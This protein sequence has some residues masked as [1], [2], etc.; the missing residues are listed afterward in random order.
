VLDSLAL[1]KELGK[2]SSSRGGEEA[3]MHISKTTTT[4]T[5]TTTTT[6]TQHNA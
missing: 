3:K 5:T 2:I 1:K 6:T 4:I